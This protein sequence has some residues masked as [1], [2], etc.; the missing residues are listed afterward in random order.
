MALD[1]N[2]HLHPSFD[3][4]LDPDIALGGHTSVAG[5]PTAKPVAY[6]NDC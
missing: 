3:V 4:F 1:D 2:T 6:G 5:L